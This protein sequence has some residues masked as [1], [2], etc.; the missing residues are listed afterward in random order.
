MAT[1]D[2]GRDDSAGPV[3][4]VSDPDAAAVDADDPLAP[5]MVVVDREQ[6]PDERDPAVVMSRPPVP[7]EQWNLDHID[8]TLAD[9]NPDY[10]A[11]ARPVIVIY[12]SRFEDTEEYDAIPVPD[13]VREKLAAGDPV[14]IAATRDLCKFYVFPEPRLEPTGE[15]WPA[16]PPTDDGT[17]AE[18]THID[19]GAPTP[20]GEDKAESAS[21]VDSDT[22]TSTEENHDCDAREDLDRLASVVREAGFSG[23]TQHDG[24]IEAT[25]LGET[26]RINRDGAVIEGG[27]FADRLASFIEKREES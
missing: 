7:A 11:D 8:G 3:D 16:T 9:D 24:K 19:S 25:K 17:E 26:Y 23:V 13:A 1:D 2:R 10:P 21:G 22:E 18:A 5:G 12:R 20:E 27:A 4:D 6:E 15:R 14:S